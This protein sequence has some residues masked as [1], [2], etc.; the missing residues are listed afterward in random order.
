MILSTVEDVITAILKQHLTMLGEALP[1]RK[2][3]SVKYQ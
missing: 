2:A 3:V 1:G